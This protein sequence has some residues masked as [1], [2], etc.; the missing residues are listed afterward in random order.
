MLYEFLTD[1]YESEFCREGY[2]NYYRSTAALVNIAN[3]TDSRSLGFIEAGCNLL[4]V[5]V[6]CSHYPVECLWRGADNVQYGGCLT[7]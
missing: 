1:A 2:F 5:G 7:L 6:K 4:L 3:R